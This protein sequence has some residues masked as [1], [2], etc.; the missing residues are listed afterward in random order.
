MIVNVLAKP[1]QDFPAFVNVGVTC[2][3]LTTGVFPVLVAV[4]VGMDP[5]PPAPKP[6]LEVSFVQE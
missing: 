2:K 3:L 1:E 6:I 4:N 5:K